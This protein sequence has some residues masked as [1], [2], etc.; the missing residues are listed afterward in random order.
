MPFYWYV[1]YGILLFSLY[2]FVV[3]RICKYLERRFNE[4]EE[5]S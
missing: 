4:K 5:D 3:I 1:I 2:L